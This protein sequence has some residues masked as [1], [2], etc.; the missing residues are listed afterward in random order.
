MIYGLP[1][2]N[3]TAKTL[4]SSENKVMTLGFHGSID[5]ALSGATGLFEFPASHMGHFCARYFLCEAS[6]GSGCRR[7]AFETSELWCLPFYHLSC[8]FLVLGEKFSK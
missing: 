1:R 2:A 6:R 8:A 5:N 7:R 4:S 3:D